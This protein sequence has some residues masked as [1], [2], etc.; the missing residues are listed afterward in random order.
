MYVYTHTHK[1][2]QHLSLSLTLDLC[3]AAGT[4]WRGSRARKGSVCAIFLPSE[5]AYRITC[6][7]VCAC[8]HGFLPY[9]CAHI[10]VKTPH[11]F[12]A[13]THNPCLILELTST[14]LVQWSPCGRRVVYLSNTHILI[15]IHSYMH[16]VVTMRT[17][18][19]VPIKHTHTHTHTH[20][21]I[22]ACSG[23]HAD[24]A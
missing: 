2:M 23:H 13:N 1:T 8:V 15:H 20:T 19:S 9:T 16:A 10:L 21:F 22:H 4:R 12:V 14:I 24:G 18:R 17:A 5:S 7:C 11:M 6:V 3:T